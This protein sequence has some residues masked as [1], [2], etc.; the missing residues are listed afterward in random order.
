LKGYFFEMKPAA[1]DREMTGDVTAAG[2]KRK[3]T[4]AMLYL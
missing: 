3:R 4:N 2:K 1:T